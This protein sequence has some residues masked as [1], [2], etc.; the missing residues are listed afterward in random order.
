MGPQA[1][2]SEHLK[3]PSSE[4]WLAGTLCPWK[5]ALPCHPLGFFSLGQFCAS[6]LPHFPWVCLEAELYWG[7]STGT[8]C[9][10]KKK[11]FT[12]ALSPLQIGKEIV[13]QSWNSSLKE[14][15]IG[16]PQWL[17]GWESACQCR[18]H[19]FDPWSGK[20]PHAE[21]WLS[22]CATTTEAYT[23]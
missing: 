12:I 18:G 4:A 17:S 14:G 13:F 6:L 20:I 3:P 22:L 8:F 7:S 9:Q 15:W 21:A 19:G 10:K 5:K 11:K 23:L 2:E 1:G 16:F